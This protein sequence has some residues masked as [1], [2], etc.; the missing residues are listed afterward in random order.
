MGQAM[1]SAEFKSLREGLGLSAQ[2]LA[3]ILGIRNERTVRHWESGGAIPDDAMAR[4]V[5]LDELVVK[6]AQSGL[7][8]FK[9]QP[10]VLV[11][12]V[13]YETEADFLRYHP[14]SI[15]HMHRLHAAAIT[16]LRWTLQNEGRRLRI[17]SM[18]PDAYEAWR[19][20]EGLPDEESTRAAWA[21]THF[22][23]SLEVQP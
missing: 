22:I 5:Q 15:P 19:A 21:T 3:D 16:R 10:A 18:L 8:A 12:V 1:T 13:R 4:L 2:A 17:L 9:E 23:G 20:A 14:K 6:M 7:E 11:A